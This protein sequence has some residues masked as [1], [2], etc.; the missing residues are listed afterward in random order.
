MEG[1]KINGRVATKRYRA[2]RF[3]ASVSWLLLAS[4]GV[5]G[6]SMKKKFPF[7]R[8]RSIAVATS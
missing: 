3:V 6:R 4:Q 5:T 2:A 1:Q 8:G 7:Q